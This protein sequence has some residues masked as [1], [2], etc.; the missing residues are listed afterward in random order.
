VLRWNQRVRNHL[1][2]ALQLLSFSAWPLMPATDRRFFKAAFGLPLEMYA[3]RG[4]EKAILQRRRPDL[5]ALPVDTNSYRFEPLHAEPG[6]GVARAFEKLGRQLRRAAQPFLRSSDP[7]RYQRVFNVD[8]PRWQ[9]VRMA[10]EPR[11]L[12]SRTPLAVGSPI[13]L[14]AGLAFVLEEHGV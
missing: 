13:R 8:E 6:H 11:R 10:V 4:V 1:G 2:A 7:R 14:V 9:Q 12:R 5:A 3:G